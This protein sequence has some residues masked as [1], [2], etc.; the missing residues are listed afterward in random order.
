[1]KLRIDKQ[2]PNRFWHGRKKYQWVDLPFSINKIIGN[3]IITAGGNFKVRFIGADC[4]PIVE[5]ISDCIMPI[6]CSNS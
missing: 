6:L 2:H 3:I 1:M 4:E 5:Q